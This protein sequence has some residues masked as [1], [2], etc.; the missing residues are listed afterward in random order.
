M[1]FSDI[2]DYGNH[3]DISEDIYLAPQLFAW[4]D[5][6]DNLSQESAT[7]E[8][9]LFSASSKVLL[10]NKPAE[11]LLLREDA[12]FGGDLDSLLQRA[13]E[14]TQS[15]G[16]WLYVLGI[17]SQGARIVIYDR[18]RVN[19]TLKNAR[20]T[21]LFLNS[22]YSEYF[23]AEDFF[24]EIARRWEET[25]RIPHEIGLALGYPIKDV[26]G[27]L[28]L[29]PLKYIGNYGWQVFGTSE[30]SLQIRDS[31][32]QA[33]QAALDFLDEP[34]TKEDVPDKREE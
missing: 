4:K 32:D 18:G 12:S 3:R 17:V 23:L 2:E 26:V 29:S 5:N 19:K 16:L 25:G 8:K 11:L 9:Y 15:W 34:G 10:G 1:D 20:H 24:A 30:P 6:L 21:V 28:E 33:K 14:L 22:G 27:Y 31:Y 7:F 13:R